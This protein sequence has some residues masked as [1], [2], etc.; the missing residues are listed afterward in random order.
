MNFIYCDC[1]IDIN[2]LHLI[3]DNIEEYE[4]NIK[5]SYCLYILYSDSNNYKYIGQTYCFNKRLRQ[6]KEKIKKYNFNKC[7]IIF[8]RYFNR[9]ILDY[10]ENLCIEYMKAENIN[11]IINKVKGNKLPVN[12]NTADINKANDILLELWQ[13]KLYPLGMVQHK[14]LD[15]LKNTNIF[16]YSPFKQLSQQQDKIIN[17]IINTNDSTV[18]HG[19]AGSGKSVMIISLLSRLIDKNLKIGLIVD[20]NW[21][22]TAKELLNFYNIRGTVVIGTSTKII[23]SEEYFDLI[24][25]DEAHK[26]S[27]KHTKQMYTFNKVYDIPEFRNCSSHLEILTKISNR[28]IL[29][30]DAFQSFRPAHISHKDFYELTKDFKQYKLNKQYRI[31][32]ELAND[33]VDAIKYILYKDTGILNEY[34]FNKNF[35]RDIFNNSYFNFLI[36]ENPISDCMELLKK[37]NHIHPNHTNRVLS[38]LNEKWKI[39]DG[40]DINIKHFKEDNGKSYRWNSTQDNWLNISDEDKEEQIGSVFAVQGKDLNVCGVILGEDLGVDKNGKLF[41]D[42]KNFHNRNGVF[43]KEEREKYQ[44]DFTLFVLNIYY[45]LLTRAIDKIYISVR[46]NPDLVNYINNIINE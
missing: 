4:D 3:G 21:Q 20:T 16:R 45:I 26:L 35:N 30:Y 32:N 43:N 1:K 41:G 29:F 37:D 15:V 5:S 44:D 33:Y 42:Y 27:R 23:N 17:D 22:K 11:N 18:V 19:D 31:N 10:I 34:N 7:L 24:I 13:R 6:H 12:I 14:S 9:T 28:L 40:K 25:V 36:S 46:N 39:S 8:S 2:T 38:G